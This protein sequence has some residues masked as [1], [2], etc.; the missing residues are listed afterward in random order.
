MTNL[1]AKFP[2]SCDHHNEEEVGNDD[3]N[4][5]E[6]FETVFPIP[7]ITIDIDW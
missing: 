7:E 5:N 6:D 1:F 4:R 2:R 3:Q